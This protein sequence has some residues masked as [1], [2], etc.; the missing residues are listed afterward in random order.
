MMKDKKLASPVS[1][2]QPQSR[3]FGES[4]VGWVERSDTHHRGAARNPAW[5]SDFPWWRHPDGAC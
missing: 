5:R 4:I 3:V 1:D 2:W